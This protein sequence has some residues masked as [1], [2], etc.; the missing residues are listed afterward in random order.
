MAIGLP[1][2]HDNG[3]WLNIVD[4]PHLSQFYSLF[5]SSLDEETVIFLLLKTLMT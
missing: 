1:C 4:S 2:C 3:E 5:Q